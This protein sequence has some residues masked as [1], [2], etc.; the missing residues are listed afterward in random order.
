MGNR[1]PA[2]CEYYW[3]S[4][5]SES[6]GPPFYIENTGGSRTLRNRQAHM[7][8]SERPPVPPSIPP[9]FATSF[10]SLSDPTPSSGSPRLK[11]DGRL[12]VH[13]P[14]QALP[15]RLRLRIRNKAPGG[16]LQRLLELLFKF[17]SKVCIP[18]E[19]PLADRYRDASVSNKDN[20]F[21]TLDLS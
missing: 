14:P 9:R 16:T 5:D 13:Q 11:F 7:F 21:Q 10:P 1:G 18:P 2:L 17:I 4:L 8:I 20:R 12:Q 3:N 19:L 15:W 6:Q